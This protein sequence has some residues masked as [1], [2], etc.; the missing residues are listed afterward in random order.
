MNSLRVARTALRARPTAFRAPLQRRTYADVAP[1]KIQ[2][3]LALPHQVCIQKQW[4][5]SAFARV[6]QAIPGQIC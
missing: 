6:A 1:D 5:N 3:S 4:S 2:L